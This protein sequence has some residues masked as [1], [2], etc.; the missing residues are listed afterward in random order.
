MYHFNR[1]SLAILPLLSILAMSPSVIESKYAERH[2]A[3]V[4]EEVKPEVVKEEVKEFKKFKEISAKVAPESIIRNENLS[5][6]DLKKQESE[7]KEKLSKIQIDSKK[8]DIKKE[9]VAQDR[10]DREALVVDLLFIEDGLLGLE[11]R[12]VL[13]ASDKEVIEKSILAHKGQIEELLLDLEKSE[14][15]LA[16]ADAP[17]EEEPKK[18]EEE[19][20]PVL[21]EEPKKEEPVVVA[22]DKKE[23]VKEEVTKEEKVVCEAEEKNALLTKQVEQLMN[24]Q[25]QIMQTMMG[26]AQ[27]MVSMYQNQNQNQQQPNPYYANSMHANPYQ[28]NQ[29][30]SSGNW[31]YYPSG[32]QPQQPNIFAPQQPQQVMPQQGGYFPDQAHMP[33]SSWNLAPQYNFQADPRY[34]VQPIMPGSFGSEAFSYNLSNPGPTNP[35]P[36]HPVA[37]GPGL[38]MVMN[39]S[40][41]M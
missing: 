37:M 25:K 15:I 38:N 20:K 34:T 13:E 16:K 24:D 33:Q 6:E 23:E 26:M 29:P 21:A 39:S 35:M 31:V 9:V 3:S 12:K 36:G 41:G 1:H 22:E 11:E 5:L 17:K 8:E 10:K 19:V 32:F 27:M 40:F 18:D 14:E 4:V 30:F 7:L 28:Y 2:I